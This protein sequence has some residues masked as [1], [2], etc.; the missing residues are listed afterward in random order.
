MK[1]DCIV[2][3]PNC[4]Y[5]DKDAL[6]NGQVTEYAQLAFDEGKTIQLPGQGDLVSIGLESDQ[7]ISIDASAIDKDG[8][9]NIDVLLD[10]RMQADITGQE[11]SQTTTKT[12]K[13]TSSEI[14]ADILKKAK[15]K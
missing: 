10:Q 2:G 13:K 5:Q 12:H 1:L 6:I 7:S 8:K 4:L 11:S 15:A 3:S 14:I 9:L